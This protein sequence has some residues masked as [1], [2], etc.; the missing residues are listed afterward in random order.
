[1]K[2]VVVDGLTPFNKCL[3]CKIVGLLEKEKTVGVLNAES[4]TQLGWQK[5]RVGPSDIKGGYEA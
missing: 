1:M 3:C 4:H 5:L 2:F